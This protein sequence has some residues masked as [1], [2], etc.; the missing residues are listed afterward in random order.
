MNEWEKKQYELRARTFALNEKDITIAELLNQDIDWTIVKIYGPKR[1]NNSYRYKESELS[2]FDPH[3]IGHCSIVDDEIIEG[4]I[5]RYLAI[6]LEV[7]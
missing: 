3:T 7:K 5:V 2:I 4:H 6:D 1:R